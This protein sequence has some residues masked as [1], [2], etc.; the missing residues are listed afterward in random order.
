MNLDGISLFVSAVF[1]LQHRIGTCSEAYSSY[2]SL[3]QT[4]IAQLLQKVL[5]RYDLFLQFR[6]Q[7]HNEITTNIQY[8]LSETV[9]LLLLFMFI[10]PKQ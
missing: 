9:V 7:P 6:K 10:S 3:A 2:F 1:L 5:A 4:D 8:L